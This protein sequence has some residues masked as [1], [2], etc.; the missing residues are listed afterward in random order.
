M[1]WVETSAEADFNVTVVDGKGRAN[2]TRW[3]T[4]RPHGDYEEV[5]AHEFGH[6]MGMYDEYTGGAIDPDS[7][8]IRDNIMGYYYRNNNPFADQYDPF[9]SWLEGNTGVDLE[10]VVDSGDHYYPSQ[11]VPEPATILFFSLGLFGIGAFRK[12]FKKA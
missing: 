6:M 11:P 12:K 9:C 8:L 10:M 7:G 5:A 2:M 3:Y 4:D 1:D